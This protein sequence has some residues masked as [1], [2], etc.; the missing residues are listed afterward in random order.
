MLDLGVL[1]SLCD[2][3]PQNMG[4][5]IILVFVIMICR[6]PTAQVAHP[7]LEH[8]S[9]LVYTALHS[10]VHTP[11]CKDLSLICLLAPLSLTH[12]RMVG[13]WCVVL[14]R[15]PRAWHPLLP[16]PGLLRGF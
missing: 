7:L 6:P 14:A 15:P 8:I 5:I 12:C 11:P 13:T 16:T 1:T 4:E 3:V 10:V 2:V 9:S